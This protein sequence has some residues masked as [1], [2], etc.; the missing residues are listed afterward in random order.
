MKLIEKNYLCFVF[1]V[2]VYIIL[3][4]TGKYFCV[5]ALILLFCSLEFPSQHAMT[6]HTVYKNTLTLQLTSE[7]NMPLRGYS[8]VDVLLNINIMYKTTKLVY[9]SCLDKNSLG[10]LI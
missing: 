8:S 7:K 5:F 2:H 1:E 9:H 3:I 10:I 4:T 6:N